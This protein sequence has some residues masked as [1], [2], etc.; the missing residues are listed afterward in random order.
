MNTPRRGARG[1]ATVELALVLPFVLALLL[2]LVQLGLVIRDQIMVVNA[3]REAARHAAV[4]PSTAVARDAAI[5]SGALDPSRLTV[6]LDS[7]G[8]AI[9][10]TVV[11]RAETEVPIVGPLLGDLT[12]RESTT[13]RREANDMP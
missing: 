11:Y 3:A 12:I 1:Q 10:V 6:S 7:S 13:M 2:F 4:D 8:V 5:R 9:T